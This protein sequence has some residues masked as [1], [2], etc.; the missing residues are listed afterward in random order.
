LRFNIIICGFDD[1]ITLKDS[2]DLLLNRFADPCW[3][4][5]ENEWLKGKIGSRECLERQL[6][7]VRMVR[8][9]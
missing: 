7:F 1:T 2:T 8:A 5:I 4:D 6:R 9:L 3:L